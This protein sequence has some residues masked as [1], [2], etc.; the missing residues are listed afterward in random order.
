L[1]TLSNVP[2]TREP[3]IRSVLRPASEP[4]VAAGEPDVSLIRRL[5][6]GDQS[7]LDPL[8]RRH[9][10]SLVALAARITGSVEDGKDV[11]QDVFVRLP[12]TAKGFREQGE[13]AAW[14]RG[15]TTKS[16]L[17]ARRRTSRRRESTETALDTL[18]DRADVASALDLSN[19]VE[20]LPPP[21]RDV[22]LLKV[23]AGYSH[24]EVAELLDIKSGTSEVRLF[25]AI[26]QLRT[27]LAD[28][29]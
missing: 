20:A 1:R 8:F 10:P 11:V 2:L 19:A 18:R 25:R 24:Q 16:A 21:L 3:P 12:V 26:R 28:G 29:A 22:F 14:L 5:R 13:A 27:L 17:N 15:V 4:V 9:A 7:A 6:D 23:V